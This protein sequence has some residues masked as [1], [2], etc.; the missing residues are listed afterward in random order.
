MITMP[1]LGAWIAITVLTVAFAPQ[2]WAA[3]AG[4]G[5]SAAAASSATAVVSAG[6]SAIPAAVQKALELPEGPERVKALSAAGV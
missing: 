1:K 5:S 6:S 2:A 3:D 4:S